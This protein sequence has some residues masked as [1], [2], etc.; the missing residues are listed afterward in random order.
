VSARAGDAVWAGQAAYTRTALAFYDPFVIGTLIRFVW[1]CPPSTLVE[2][3][4]ANVSPSHLECG[5]GTGFFLDRCRLPRHPRLVL[6]DLNPSCLARASQRLSR[7]APRVY[8]RN[9]LEPLAMDEAP[10]DSVGMNCLLHCLP[11]EMP[12]KAVVFDHVSDYLSPGG[13]VFGSSVLGAGV[14][15]GPLAK[16]LMALFNRRGIFCNAGDTAAALREEL[17]RRFR[18]S[19][20]DVIG[21]V[22]VFRARK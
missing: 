3:Y 1:K 16:R 15:P 22:A 20:V 5:V 19:S 11:G 10:F 6:L 8:R 21:C 12:A 9:V 2:L 7:Y 13:R 17:A 4:D 14:R 18:E